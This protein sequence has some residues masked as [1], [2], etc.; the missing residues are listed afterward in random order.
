MIKPIS[1]G[2]LMSNAIVSGLFAIIGTTLGWV[3]SEAGAGWRS[4]AERRRAEQAEATARVLDAARTAVAISE[5]VRW[6][7]QVDEAKK[8][9]GE[10]IDREA[11]GVKVIDLAEQLQQLRLIPLTVTAKGPRSALPQIGILVDRIQGLWNEFAETSRA[12]IADRPA[13]FLNECKEIMKVAQDLASQ[14]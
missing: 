4:Y 11:Y 3:L 5:G 1:Y 10:G 2:Q 13:R 8:L 14:P 9:H 12:D 6:L 7:V